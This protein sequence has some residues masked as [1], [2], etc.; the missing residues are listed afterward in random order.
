MWDLPLNDNHASKLLLQLRLGSNLQLLG[1]DRGSLRNAHAQHAVLEVHRSFVEISVLGQDDLALH[2]SVRAF[3]AMDSVLV[4]LM[5]MLALGLQRK[6]VIVDS[7]LQ[8][9]GIHPRQVSHHFELILLFDEIGS[10][11]RGDGS[12]HIKSGAG[13]ESTEE[14]IAERIVSQPTLADGIVENRSE[15]SKRHD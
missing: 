15:W 14:G 6:N 1:L 9:S 10:E 3:Q 7:H 13:L 12:S 5:H 2:T 4:D 11:K 8:I